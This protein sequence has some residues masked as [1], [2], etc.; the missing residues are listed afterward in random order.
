MSAA[1][2]VHDF[3]KYHTFCLLRCLRMSQ[4]A[5]LDDFNVTIS[6]SLEGLPSLHPCTK[7]PLHCCG[8]T[9]LHPTVTRKQSTNAAAARTTIWRERG[10]VS[11]FA[12]PL[13]EQKGQFEGS[14][15]PYFFSPAAK[16]HTDLFVPSVAMFCYVFPHEL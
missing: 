15:S 8:C 11:Y 10:K 14:A 5:D 12:A 4:S 9:S 1:S 13:K 3:E 6:G 7:R 2:I 16:P